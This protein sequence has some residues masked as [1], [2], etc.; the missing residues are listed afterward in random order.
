MNPGPFSHES[1]ALTTELSPSPDHRIR[2]GTHRKPKQKERW[3]GR[4]LETEGP[5]ENGAQRARE[6]EGERKT[7]RQRETETDTQTE[8]ETECLER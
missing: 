7:D 2:K 3:E 8:T 1:G 6:C 5:R 4:E